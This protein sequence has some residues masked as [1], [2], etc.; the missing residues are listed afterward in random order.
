MSAFHAVRPWLQQIICHEVFSAILCRQTA[1]YAI[2]NLLESSRRK[3]QSLFSLAEGRGRSLPICFH[4]LFEKS[5]NCPIDGQGWLLCLLK[6]QVNVLAGHCL[7][8]DH[9]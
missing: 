2:A 4:P 6:G 7:A 8:L 1:L 9:L 5:V 3:L